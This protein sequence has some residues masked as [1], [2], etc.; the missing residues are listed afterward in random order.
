MAKRVLEYEIKIDGSASTIKGNIK[1]NINQSINAI[2]EEIEKAQDFPTGHLAI[3]SPQGS[4]LTD[5]TLI[6]L[7]KEKKQS[8]YRKYSETSSIYFEEESMI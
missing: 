7:L 3:E 6:I 1:V 8:N 2:R 5:T 4:L